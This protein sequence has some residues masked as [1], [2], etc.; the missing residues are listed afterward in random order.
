ME[1]TE[2]E[3]VL[4][5]CDNGRGV[6]ECDLPYIFEKGFTGDS[7]DAGKKATGMGLYLSKKMADDLKLGLEARSERGAGFDM[8]IRFPRVRGKKFVFG[9][10]IFSDR[11]SENP[12]DTV[13]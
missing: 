7:S 5:I 11:A 2:S 6:K 10:E 4:H 8:A 9:G 1:Q 12:P 13:G 3:D